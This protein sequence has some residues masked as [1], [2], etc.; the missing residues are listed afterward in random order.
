MEHTD[1]GI[2]SLTSVNYFI[3]DLTWQSLAAHSEDGMVLLLMQA[4]ED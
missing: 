1:N 2:G 3:V 4:L